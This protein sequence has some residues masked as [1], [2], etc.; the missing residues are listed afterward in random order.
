MSIQACFLPDVPGDEGIRGLEGEPEEWLIVSFLCM[1]TGKPEAGGGAGGV[2]TPA[3]GGGGGGGGL[4]R[5]CGG[6][7]PGKV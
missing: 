4:A 3:G 5:L 7:Y 1:P 2:G 6:R